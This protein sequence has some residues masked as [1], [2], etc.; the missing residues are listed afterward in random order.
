MF[1]GE[2][3]TD[4]KVDVDASPS[5]QFTAW[6]KIVIIVAYKSSIKMPV[7]K[8]PEVLVTDPSQCYH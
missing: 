7:L 2:Y 6:T 8:D 1:I 5:D 4:I 3:T